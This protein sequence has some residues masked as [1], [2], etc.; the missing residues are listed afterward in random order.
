MPID[1]P[2][3]NKIKTID[4]FQTKTQVTGSINKAIG[5]TLYGINHQKSK[6]VLP[7]NKDDYGYTFFTRPQL[8]LQ[9]SNL[10]KDRKFFNLLTTEPNS[11]HRYVRCMLDPRL[12]KD[13]ANSKVFGDRNSPSQGTI[14]SPLVD[15]NM[16]F[17]P[18]FTNTIKTISGWPDTV[19][20]AFV[21][22]AGTFKE[23]WS[24]PDGSVEIYDAFDLSATFQN[25]YNEP[26]SL[27][28]DTWLR[29][30]ALVF[31]GITGPYIDYITENMIDYN[32][33]IYRLVMDETRRYVKKIAATG[34]AWPMND[35]TGKFFDFNDSVKYNDQTKTI[36]VR[37]KCM[38]AIYNDPILY[39]EFNEVSAI[40]NPDV[41]NMLEGKPHNLEV[42]PYDLLDLLKNRGYPI[43]D[44]DT[45]ELKW[46]I[47]KNSKSYKE[48][49]STY[50]I[51]KEEE[52]P[53]LGIETIGFTPINNG[54]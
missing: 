6:S 29:Y 39:R 46:Y 25:I 20:P 53:T 51:D 54:V 41:R 23:Q 5:N 48:L 45:Y 11:I 40:F 52:L 28:L 1:N 16:G 37:F 31:E 21:S 49:L 13:H 47:N 7:T 30:M 24:I 10:R 22:K 4:D 35:A 27:I 2:D 36:N 15:E 3:M 26:I 32:T 8:N 44:L 42:I 19:M 14:I 12:S 50:G 34:A 43:I 33:R 17:I 38:G 18:V 9:D